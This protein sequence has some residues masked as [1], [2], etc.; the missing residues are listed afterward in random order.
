MAVALTAGRSAGVS[1]RWVAVPSALH[2]CTR[3]LQIARLPFPS[4]YPASA[5]SRR[6]LGLISPR[7][8][9]GGQAGTVFGRQLHH[10]RGQRFQDL[11]VRWCAG[12]CAALSSKPRFFLRLVWFFRVPLG[13]SWGRS[14]EPPAPEAGWREKGDV[15]RP[16]ERRPA[17]RATELLWLL[18]EMARWPVSGRWPRLRAANAFPWPVGGRGQRQRRRSSRTAGVT[19]VVPA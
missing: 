14:C 19:S 10:G 17:D 6:C 9:Q 2:G 11:G 18:R 7:Y 5:A 3:F 12:I 13:A 4:Q 16:E 1:G 8:Q 15:R